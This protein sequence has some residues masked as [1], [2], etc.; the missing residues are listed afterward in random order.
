M[1]DLASSERIEHLKQEIEKSSASTRRLERELVD[2]ILQ[3]NG[4][5]RDS[6]ILAATTE[7][8]T[9]WRKAQ[10]CGVHDPLG[11]EPV[12]RAVYYARDD[13]RIIQPVN[14]KRWVPFPD[15]IGDVAAVISE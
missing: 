14:V 10:V 2:E 13:T 8:E 15:S 11:D 4:L 9:H 7:L 1:N 6:F 12:I 3:R 5:H